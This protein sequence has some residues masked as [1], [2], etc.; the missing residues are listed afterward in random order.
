M[1]PEEW[2]ANYWAKVDR[3]NLERWLDA[4]DDAAQ[5]TDPE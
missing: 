4:F 2:E 1:S 5:E 3:E